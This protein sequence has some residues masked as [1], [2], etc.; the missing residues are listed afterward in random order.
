MCG[1]QLFIHDLSALLINLS[2]AEKHVLAQY[3]IVIQLY[4]SMMLLDVPADD[5]CLLLR[6][7]FVIA[8][9]DLRKL[10]GTIGRIQCIDGHVDSHS[11]V[12][13][14]QFLSFDV[15]S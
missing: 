1:C 5:P 12:F 15:T 13:R 3:S 10:F 9:L 8:N 11:P 6:H 14:Q 4:R 7:S 2:S